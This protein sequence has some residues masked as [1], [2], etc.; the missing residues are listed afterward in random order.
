MN[1]QMIAAEFLA[2]AKASMKNYAS[3]IAETASPEVRNI[4]KTHLNDAICVHEKLTEY[5]IKKGFYNANNPQQ[6]FKMDMQA[7]DTALNLK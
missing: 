3:S 5:M 2:S 7:A 1:E 4:L 6:Q